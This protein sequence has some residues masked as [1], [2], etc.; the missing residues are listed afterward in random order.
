[1]P[2]V[3]VRDARAED[4]AAI[5]DIWATA[6]P[7]LVRSADRAAADIAADATLGRRHWVGLIDG[8]T[9]GTAM[10]RAI[11]EDDEDQLFV[12]V[13]VHPDYGSRGVGSALLRAA[14]APF[15][16]VTAM[17]SISRDDPISLG[18]AVRNGFLPE[19]EHQICR[20]EPASASA[21]GPPPHGFHAVDLSGLEDLQ[22]LL[23]TYNQAAH[24]DPSGLSRVFSLQEFRAGWWNSPDNAPEV[25]WALLADDPASSDGPVVAAFTSVQLDRT[26]GRA[27]SAMTATHPS[28]RGRGLATWVKRRSL[29]ALAEASVHE[30]WAAN[31]ATN[32]PMIAVNDSL[33]YQ[34]AAK[35]ISVRRRLHH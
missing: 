24:D 15:P 1:M 9:V 35:S 7:Y 22:Q 19:G 2:E 14:V 26:R 25:S 30:A 4:C 17:Q 11:H 6:V 3:T 31:D 18:F 16:G 33:G 13:E 28:Y 12:A 29:N 27:W 21:A 20:I 8:R 5:A 23:D 34:P 10:A 32:A